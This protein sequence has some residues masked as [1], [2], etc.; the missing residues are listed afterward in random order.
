VHGKLGELVITEPM[1]SMPLFFWNDPDGSRYRATYF[2]QYPG[3]WR[4][5]DWLRFTDTGALI[6]GRS[7]ATLNRQGVRVG[8]SEIY[9]AVEAL[10]EVVDSL[11][12]GLEQPD[13]GYY[14]PLFVVL[15]DG[16]PLDDALRARIQQQIRTGLSPRFVPDT[17][18]QA[19]AVPRTITGKKLEVPIKRMLLGEPHQHVLQAGAL[20]E[21]AA[22]DFFV[23]FAMNLTA[24]GTLRIRDAR[25]EE[26][27]AIRELTQRAYAEY[28]RLMTPGAWR[29]LAEAVNSALDTAEPVQRIVAE[30]GAQ[31]VGSVMLYSAAADAYAGAVAQARCPEVR[32]LAVDPEARGLGVGRALMDECIRRARLAGAAELGL[33]TSASMRAALQLYEQMGFVRAPAYDFQPEGAELVTAFRLDLAPR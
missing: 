3:V 25:P 28:E 9:R 16:C 19:P 26:R 7:D 14:M 31:L 2:S 15:R 10:P 13:G 5:G 17:I 6:E 12:V 33:H 30:R 4:H 29:A 21:P 32:M 24:S 8:S 27:G 18:V 20:Q 11:V 22:L 23:E 1:P